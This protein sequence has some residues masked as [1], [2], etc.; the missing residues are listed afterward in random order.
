[1]RRPEAKSLVIGEIEQDEVEAFLWKEVTFTIANYFNV[2]L[3]KI[4][5][6]KKAIVDQL[7]PFINEL[8]RTLEKQQKADSV[9]TAEYKLYT[10]FLHS[11]VVAYHEK[12]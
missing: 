5:K 9:K 6:I 7:Y 4:N 8:D 1:M 2:G 10:A 3:M 11:R 12:I